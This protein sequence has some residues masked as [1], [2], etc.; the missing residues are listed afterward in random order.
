MINIT[1]RCRTCSWSWRPRTADGTD[2]DY[3]RARD[4][5]FAHSRGNTGHIVEA[6]REGRTEL[7]AGFRSVSLDIEVIST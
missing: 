5:A 7:N 6:R 1:A 2:E 4:T 3:D